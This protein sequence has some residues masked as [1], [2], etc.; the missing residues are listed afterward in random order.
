MRRWADRYIRGPL[1]GVGI[2]GTL[3]LLV[4]V[5]L[6][7]VS[8]MVGPE[9]EPGGSYELPVTPQA[10]SLDLLPIVPTDQERSIATVLTSLHP[11]ATPERTLMLYGEI[12]K[13]LVKG[14][15]I[16]MEEAQHLPGLS[17][18]GTG[19]YVD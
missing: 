8:A 16:E 9:Y 19:A 1:V 11:Q 7:K 15:I 18:Y 5:G 3:L 12:L 2:L 13:A 14:R 10:S 6:V 4:F 17:S